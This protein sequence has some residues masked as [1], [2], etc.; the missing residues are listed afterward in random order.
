LSQVVNKFFFANTSSEHL[1][2][3]NDQHA[4]TLTTMNTRT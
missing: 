3:I 2:R 4:R 1:F